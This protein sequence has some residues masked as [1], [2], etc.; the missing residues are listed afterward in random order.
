MNYKRMIEDAKAKGLTSEKMMY[1]SID[2]VDAMLC[3]MEKEHPKEYWAFLRKQHGLLYA[4]HYTEEFAMWDVENMK[5]LGMYWT[6]AQVE[7]A[8]KNMSFPSGTTLCDKFVAFNA[9]AND[10]KDVLKDEDI[11]KVAYAFWFN[12]KDWKGKGKIWE[13]MALN[14]SM[15]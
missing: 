15:G 5:P 10:L 4:N 9:S 12:D 3:M 8:T 13:Y 6:K 1:Q 14:H 11:L 2:D 7:E